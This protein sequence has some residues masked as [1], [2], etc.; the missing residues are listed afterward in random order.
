MLNA[1]EEDN[2]MD[3]GDEDLINVRSCLQLLMNILCVF[4]FI[5]LR[6]RYTLAFF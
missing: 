5:N 6:A 2:N 4:L 1:D 3:E